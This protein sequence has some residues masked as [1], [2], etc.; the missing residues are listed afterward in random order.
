MS[1]LN[2]EKDSLLGQVINVQ[3]PSYILDQFAFLRHSLVV[4]SGH[5][6]S[7]APVCCYQK[8]ELEGQLWVLG[9][10]HPF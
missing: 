10:V 1:T 4:V 5:N 6:L 3:N 8:E 7:A 9:P 2:C